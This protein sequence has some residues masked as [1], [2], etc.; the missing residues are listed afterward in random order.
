MFG[1]G[2]NMLIYFLSI[3]GPAKILLMVM[4]GCATVL[5]G[6]VYAVCR[7]DGKDDGAASAR[8][9]C[10]WAL[11][12]LCAGLL[13]PHPQDVVQAYAM[14][15]GAKVVTADNAEAA[16]DG[17]VKRVDALIEALGAK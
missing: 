17:A 3:A 12:A 2:G 1:H 13:V 7:E 6:I 15:E 11:G 16:V 8:K 9:V 4:G 5:A 14:V 10:L